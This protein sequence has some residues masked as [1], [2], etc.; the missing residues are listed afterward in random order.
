M[1][2]IDPIYF[3]QPILTIAFSAGLVIYW[4]FKRKFTG[5]V[6]I[7]S[8]LAFAGAIALKVAVQAVTYNAFLGVF[9]GNLSALGIYFGVQTVFFEVGGAFLV[10]AWAFS[11]GKMNLKDA[12]A[13]GLGLGFWENAVLLGALSVFNL[14]SVYLALA[15]GGATAQTVFSQLLNTR[16]EL[17]YP[18]SQVLTLIGFGLLERVTSQ[19]FHFSW[20]Y[21]CVIAA[22]LHKKYFLVAL[23][24]GFLDFFV[25]FASSIGIPLFESFIFVLGLGSLMLTLIVRRS[26]PSE[27]RG[28][29]SLQ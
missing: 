2:N 4:H 3:L 24:L 9:K 15:F 5:G 16:P 13:Y 18:P 12:E 11:R 17:F 22:V 27:C 28:S 23:P 20:G 21:L 8:L 1:Q 19:M 6:L 14:V 29:S 25:P 10:A 7:Y 26:L